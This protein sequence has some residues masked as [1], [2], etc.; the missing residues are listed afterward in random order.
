MG[1]RG[2][3]RREVNVTSLSKEEAKARSVGLTVGRSTVAIWRRRKEPTTAVKKR[4]E[5]KKEALFF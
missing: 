2:W 5:A 4:E 1:R 3:E